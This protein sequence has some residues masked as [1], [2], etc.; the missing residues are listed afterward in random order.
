MIDV[1][2][3]MRRREFIAGLGSV[4][5]YPL[6]GRAQQAGKV[7]RI[8]FLGAPSPNDFADHIATF[9]AGLRDLGYIEGS[10]IVI[11]YRWA[12]GIYGRLPILAAE[13]VRSN[14]DLIITQ[15]TT[16]S[17][18]AKQ[19]TTSIPIIM[20]NVGDPVASG[21][22]ASLARPG[23]N[24]TGL[25]VFSPEIHSKRIEL[26]QK[27]LP[28]IVKVAAL[29]NADSSINRGEFQAMERAAQLLKVEVKP[30]PVRGPAEF[31]SAFDTMVKD[32]IE[33]VEISDDAMLNVNWEAFAALS[34]ERRLPS[35]GN[36][37]IARAGGLIGLLRAEGATAYR[38]WPQ[39]ARLRPRVRL[40]RLIVARVFQQICAQAH[41]RARNSRG[42]ADNDTIRARAHSRVRMNMSISAHGARRRT[43]A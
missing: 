38:F 35:V 14:V 21:L 1:R 12:E 25:S 24:I 23:G 10:N 37:G 41:S 9:K 3:K 19:A 33:A 36:I 15:G 22:V 4:A 20:V 7:A 6:I 34:L 40:E 17:I 5:G 43:R 18:A 13:L 39:Y 8:G 11:E 27:V 28:R 26:L 29:F 32:R 2:I 42:G 16:G 30:F 31:K